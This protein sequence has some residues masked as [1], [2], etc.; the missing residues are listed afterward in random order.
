MEY[1]IVYLSYGF[2]LLLIIYNITAS[3]LISI[4]LEYLFELLNKIDQKAIE[5]PK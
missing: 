5:Y 4:L 3:L 1:I 2:D